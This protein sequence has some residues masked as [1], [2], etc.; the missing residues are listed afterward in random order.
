[1]S[2]WLAALAL[3]LPTPVTHG[4]PL[5]AA[6]RFAALITLQTQ[7]VGLQEDSGPLGTAMNSFSF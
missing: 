3:W 2:S 1:M 4:Q 6:T 7:P 5:R